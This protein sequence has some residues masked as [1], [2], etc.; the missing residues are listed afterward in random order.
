MRGKYNSHLGNYALVT[1]FSSFNDPLTFYTNSLFD[2]FNKLLSE[3]KY[4]V[5]LLLV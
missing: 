5:D 1:F 4:L 2:F 3:V